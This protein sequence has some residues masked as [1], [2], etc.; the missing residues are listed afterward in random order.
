MQSAIM[1]AHTVPGRRATLASASGGAVIESASTTR[2]PCTCLSQRGSCGATLRSRARFAAT[3]DEALQRLTPGAWD[4]L[5]LDIVMPG[6]NILD[7]LARIRR[8]NPGLP[9]L[10]LTA[11]S[12]RAY[13]L[14]MLQAG[15]NGYVNKSQAAEELV[16]AVRKVLRIDPIQAT[17]TQGVLA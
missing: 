13:P 17:G 9:I 11:I 3:A 15:A 12:E 4:L 14:R 6:M 7:S 16:A 5:L 1:I 8:Q 2:A 10:I